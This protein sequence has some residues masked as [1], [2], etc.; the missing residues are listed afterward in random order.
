MNDFNEV[1]STPAPSTYDVTEWPV[2]RHAAPVQVPAPAEDTAKT[3]GMQRPVPAYGGLQVPSAPDVQ[4]SEPEVQV[5]RAATPQATP[6]EPNRPD[7][8]FTVSVD[9]ARRRLAD[10]GLDRSKDTIQRY[11]REGSLEARKL[12]LFGKYF[13]T[14]DSMTS[15]IEKMQHDAGESPI[16]QQ[17]AGGSSDD[18]SGMQVHEAA[19]DEVVEET[20][21]LHAGASKSAQVDATTNA[22]ARSSSDEDLQ[23]HEAARRDTQR[24]VDLQVENAKLQAK[25]EAQDAL[26]Q[27]QK[28]T[29][30]FLKEEVTEARRNRGDMKDMS[31]Q[32]FGLLRTISLRGGQSDSSASPSGTPVHAE[33]VRSDEKQQSGG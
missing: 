28:E 31:E 2:Q 33:V 17:D 16:V 18:Y 20:P 6:P 11:C 14:E 9:E 10:I 1:K 25:L 22:G 26:V 12:G 21:D 3:I 29:I 13:I 8:A 4:T 24:E 15:F 7:S 27:E 32:M 30:S 19:A 5:H 23:V